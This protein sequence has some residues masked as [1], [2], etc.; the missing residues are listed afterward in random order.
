MKII[1]TFLSMAEFLLARAFP[2]KIAAL[3][4][5]QSDIA[6]STDYLRRISRCDFAPSVGQALPV[7]PFRVQSLGRMLIFVLVF[8]FSVAASPVQAQTA[9]QY[10]NEMRDTNTFNH[11]TDK[12]VC[13]RD[14]AVP[15]FI[16]VSAIEDMIDAVTRSGDVN[17]AKIFAKVQASGFMLSVQTY[18]K[19]VANGDPILYEKM[20][21]EYRLEGK[22]P[23]HARM[24][25]LINWKTGR[26]R[27]KVFALDYNKN[28]PAY[29]GSGKCELIHSW[30]TPSVLSGS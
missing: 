2:P 15:S 6:E 29:E 8:G 19:G 24:T 14:D 25:Y 30:D 5:E 21:K 1:E 7:L 26:Y 3:E 16:V 28:L 4:F 20:G 10:F 22:V 13:F 18:Y 27:L 9:R 23:I 12:Y 17:G 11:I